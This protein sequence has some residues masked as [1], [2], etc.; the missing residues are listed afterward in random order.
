[1]LDTVLIV[2]F[3]DDPATVE[4][5]IFGMVLG[6]RVPKVRVTKELTGAHRSELLAGF[7]EGGAVACR[8]RV[9][10]LA[11]WSVVGLSWPSFV[12]GLT[13]A[14][15]VG[16]LIGPL[17]IWVSTGTREVEAG[18]LRIRLSTGTCE[19]KGIRI[20]GLSCPKMA[21]ELFGA[22]IAGELTGMV[23]VGRLIG[24]LWVGVTTGNW[25]VLGLTDPRLVVVITWPRIVEWLIGIRGV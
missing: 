20:V 1:M 14:R 25:T 16:V 17:G 2:L 8:R 23:K 19:V 6:A 9:E 15:S 22:R 4:Q 7:R 13:W 24:L 12:A 18:P 10:M 21:L 11:G 5:C 3:V